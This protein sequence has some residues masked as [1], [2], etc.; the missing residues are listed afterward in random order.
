MTTV[1]TTFQLHID[2]Q[3][4]LEKT[5]VLKELVEQKFGHLPQSASL[6]VKAGGFSLRFWSHP[7]KLHDISGSLDYIIEKVRELDSP[8]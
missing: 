3:P 5:V 1:T 2:I 4:L 8:E 7:D 6:R